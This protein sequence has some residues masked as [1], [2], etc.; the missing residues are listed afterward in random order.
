MALDVRPSV[1]VIIP[2]YNEEAGLPL[3]LAAIPRG[4]VAET[5]VVDNGS[6][7]TSAAIAQS[8]GARVVSEPRRG[9]G[10]ACLA[11]IEAASSHD[12]LVFLDGDF[13]DYP[14]D[15][16]DLLDP[17]V[18]GQAD[19]ALGTR[20]ILPESRRALLPQARFGNRLAAVLMRLLFGIRCSPH[21][22]ICEILQPVSWKSAAWD[23]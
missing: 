11:G 1:G 19:L 14:E 3:V 9:Y 23:S 7:D 18:G 16:A 10:S 12:I 13:S 6:T 21:S 5:V 15:M 20:M 4:L 22:V 17:V 2:V 8:H